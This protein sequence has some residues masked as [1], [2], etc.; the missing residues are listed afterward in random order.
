MS[1]Q[2][3]SGR[4]FLILWPSQNIR[5][6]QIHFVKIWCMIFGWVGNWVLASIWRCLFQFMTQ[7]F[8]HQCKELCTFRYLNKSKKPVIIQFSSF[9]MNNSTLWNTNEEVFGHFILG[10]TSLFVHAY[11]IF[12]CHAISDYQGLPIY[13]VISNHL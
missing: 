3:L 1:N 4:F 10:G 5:T 12:I 7:A 11:A 2:I 13:Y 9:K 6:L 8:I